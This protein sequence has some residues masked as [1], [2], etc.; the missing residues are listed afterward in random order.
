MVSAWARRCGVL[1]PGL[2][3]GLERYLELQRSL[4]DFY[5]QSKP[6]RQFAELTCPCFSCMLSAPGQA[7]R[8]KASR[9]PPGSRDSNGKGVSLGAAGLLP[10]YSF[11]V[12]APCPPV[13]LSTR[14]GLWE[15]KN[16]PRWLIPLLAGIL[17]AAA[18]LVYGWV[19]NPVKFVDTTPAS[20]RADY[21]TDYVLMVAESYSADHDAALASRRLAIFGSETPAAIAGAALQTG[22]RFGYSQDDMALIQELTRALQAYQP[23]APTAGSAP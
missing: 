2:L 16:M 6:R 14:M 3:L 18:G 10:G 7:R 20:L 1:V 19:I 8:G 22:E 13:T 9:T 21:R 11:R 17:G 12:V 15:N 4:E 23:V 5:S